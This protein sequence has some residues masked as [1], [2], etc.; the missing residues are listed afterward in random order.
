MPQV[1]ISNQVDEEWFVGY[2]KAQRFIEE[3]GIRT[4]TLRQLFKEKGIFVFAFTK[5][6]LG[7]LCPFFMLNYSN[8]E[9]LNSLA[10]IKVYPSVGGFYIKFD[11]EKSFE[12]IKEILCS[13]P[14]HEKDEYDVNISEVEI[15][16]SYLKAKLIYKYERSTKLFFPE[17][18][19]AV[20]VFIEK[21]EDPTIF[22]VYGEIFR[23]MD[24]SKMRTF[25]TLN[26][27]KDNFKVIDLNFSKLSSSSDKHEVIKNQVEKLKDVELSIEE[28]S[29]CFK[30]L[31]TYEHRADRVADLS[32]SDDISYFQSSNKLNTETDII[33]PNTLID[34]LENQAGKCLSFI[35]CVYYSESQKRYL[36]ISFY[37][38][39]Q[40]FVTFN[41]LYL[42]PKEDEEIQH[43]TSKDEL[44]NFP[45]RVLQKKEISKILSKIWIC[46]AQEL[47]S[48]FENID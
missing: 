32:P 48:S 46:S 10:G 25:F 29:S 22:V 38:G 35:K 4:Q 47:Y 11:E 40:F 44:Y 9:M 31:G 13:V 3:S 24:F 6:N 43:P 15:N 30:I 17:S 8:A 21:T 5:E 20:K 16:D 26:H 7:L 45:R 33:N 34:Q 37:Y 2:A 23:Y 36:S 19:I 39:N 18:P 42:Y 41:S 12:Q 14:Q 28:Q 1:N 27:L